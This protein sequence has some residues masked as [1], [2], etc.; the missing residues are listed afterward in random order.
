MSVKKIVIAVIILLFLLIIATN[1]LIIR[2]I[3]FVGKQNSN[4]A[5]GIYTGQSLFDMSPGKIK[6]PV[7]TFR[8]V[9]DIKASFV[10]DPFMVYEDNKWFM[11]FEVWNTETNQGD[12]AL[13]TSTDGIK[14]VYKKVVID[15]LFHLSYPYVFKWHDEYFMIP[16]S[17]GRNSIGLYKAI[18]FPE[19]WSF[20]RT[21][22]EGKSFKDSSV[23]HYRNKWWLFTEDSNKKDIFDT[24]RLYYA[25]NLTGPWFEHPDNPI[26]E[27]N[28]HISRPGGRV[29]IYDDYV[30]RF[31]QDD[32]PIYGKSVRA[33]KITDLGTTSYK[34]EEMDHNLFFGPSGNGWNAKR[35]HHIDLHPVGRNQWIACLDGYGEELVFGLKY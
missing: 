20:E 33:F 26:I 31:A 24:L 1:T 34:E 6:N 27:G 25:D 10:A 7:L 30:I 29:I 19:Q 32:D 16:E 9:T 8:D 13:A 12:I 14:W 28:T 5:I 4:W 3:P 11:F 21:L 23:V 22:L 35:M 18:N 17:A 15:E 2:G